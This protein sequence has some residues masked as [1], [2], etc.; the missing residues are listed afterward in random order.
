MLIKISARDIST[1][2]VLQNSFHNGLKSSDADIK[3]K[4]VKLC[5]AMSLA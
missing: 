4:E 2:K 1:V 5:Q 3:I